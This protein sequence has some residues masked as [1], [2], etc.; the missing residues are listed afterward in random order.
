MDASTLK[1]RAVVSLTEGTKL[2]V[3]AQPLFD[4]HLSHVRALAVTD[5]EGTFFIPFDQLQ[6][7]GADVVTVASQQ[8]IED[9]PADELIALG[10]IIHLKVVDQAGTFVGAITHVELE[11]TSGRVAHLVAHKGGVLGI[12]G[13]N[14]PIDPTTI[15]SVGADLMTL[16]TEVALPVH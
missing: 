10:E 1:G 7:V 12:G 2:G 16:A 5:E 11:P 15:L 4:A 3:I 8:V 9:A 6:S 14:T 13:T